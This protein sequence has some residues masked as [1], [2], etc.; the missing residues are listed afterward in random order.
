MLARRH[1][2]KSVASAVA[3]GD[4]QSKGD[5]TFPQEGPWEKREIGN[6]PSHWETTRLKATDG[7]NVSGRVHG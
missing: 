3:T 7:G 2:T 6:Q 1:R 5:P 4:V